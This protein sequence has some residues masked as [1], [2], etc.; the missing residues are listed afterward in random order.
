MVLLAKLAECHKTEQ[1]IPVSQAFKQHAIV[2]A[3]IALSQSTHIYL[4]V[5][6]NGHKANTISMAYLIR[7]IIIWKG[8]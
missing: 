2:R 1:L 6:E 7:C 3:Y 4:L 8:M 5:V